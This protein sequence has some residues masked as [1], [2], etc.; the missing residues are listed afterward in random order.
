MYSLMIENTLRPGKN[1]EFLN[2]WQREILPLLKKQPGFVEAALLSGLA[3][4][5]LLIG[6]SF[7][8]SEADAQRYYT[9]V[10]PG[11]AG[12]VSHYF[13]FSPMVRTFA[14]EAS[15]ALRVASNRAA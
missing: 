9:E 1:T 11:I 8:R 4:H 15:E 2:L 3:D 12:S 10:F 13:E 6:I 5:R 7:W 14:V